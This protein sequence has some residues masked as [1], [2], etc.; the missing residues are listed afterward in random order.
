MVC[1]VTGYSRGLGQAIVLAF[2]RRK[3]KVVVHFKDSYK[4]AEH[5]ASLIKESLLLRA[6]VRNFKQVKDLTDKVVKKWGRIDVLVNNAGITKEALLIK[7]SEK[8]FDDT[9]NTNLKGPFNF[10]RSV[11]RVMM[12]QKSGRIIN[13]SSIARE[14]PGTF[15]ECFNNPAFPAMSAGAANL[16][17]CQNGKFQGITANTIPKGWYDTKLLSAEVSTIS[18]FKNSSALSA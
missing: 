11:S 2:G 17:T 12:K 18:G 1:L 16:N 14:H 3:H 6:D 15:G 13:I 7:T 5:V 10:I 9:V 4:K 8:D